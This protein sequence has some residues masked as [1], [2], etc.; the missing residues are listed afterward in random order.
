MAA[1]DL[2]LSAPY[3]PRFDFHPNPDESHG[4]ANHH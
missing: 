1:L 4:E 3:P 2:G